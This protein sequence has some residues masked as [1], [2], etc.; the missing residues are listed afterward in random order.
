M[1][2]TA[3]LAEPNLP[4]K[5]ADISIITACRKFPTKCTKTMSLCGH[6]DVL[7][8]YESVQLH[9][10][11]SPFLPRARFRLAFQTS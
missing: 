7:N 3:A 11:I 8:A 4:R 6:F 2:S 10:E 1:Y 9:R 5:C